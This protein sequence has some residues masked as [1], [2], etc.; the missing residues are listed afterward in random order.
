MA[1]FSP[2]YILPMFSREL[3]SEH[4][5]A[6]GYAAS[7]ITVLIDAAVTDNAMRNIPA[8]ST[9]EIITTDDPGLPDFAQVKA[10]VDAMTDIEAVMI[11]SDDV[12]NQKG[13]CGPAGLDPAA[14]ERGAIVVF[15][16]LGVL[17]FEGKRL[18]ALEID[19]A[20]SNFEEIRF[21]GI[22]HEDD[23][24]DAITASPAF[25]AA[26][27]S[28]RAWL[29]R[30]RDPNAGHGSIHDAILSEIANQNDPPIESLDMRE[31]R[32]WSD[33]QQE[34]LQHT[35]VMAWHAMRAGFGVE[36]HID[37]AT[38]TEPHQMC[39]CALYERRNMQEEAM[40]AVLDCYTD[41]IDHLFDLEKFQGWEWDYSDGIPDRISGYS[42][43]PICLLHG[44][45][46]HDDSNV[47]R[48]AKI[49][50][51]PLIKERLARQGLGDDTVAE[52][53]ARIDAA[54]SGSG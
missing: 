17:R 21:P 31:R 50:A 42:Q 34:M 13:W 8:K 9:M 48:H 40:D 46:P 16:D 45:I 1:E 38:E 20:R 11:H 32:N 7:L 24:I 2:E 43:V 44:D 36:I 52:L 25:R 15:P 23:K 12:A 35:V 41:L 6:R 26:H 3:D 4:G 51:R 27:G 53:F 28:G 19:A 37:S 10:L 33:E 39:V 5:K 47:S 49:G 14:P 22:F 30:T 54:V 29:D 18:S